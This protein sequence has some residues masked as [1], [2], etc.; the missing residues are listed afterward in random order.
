MAGHLKIGS[1][2]V[3]AAKS[4]VTNDVPDGKQMSGYPLREHIE[5]LRIKMAMGKVPELVKRIKKLE[6]ELEK[7]EAKK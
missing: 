6:K 7:T 2:V 3:I 4:G 5:D 1:N